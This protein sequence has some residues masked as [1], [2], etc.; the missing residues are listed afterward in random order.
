MTAKAAIKTALNTSTFVPIKMP[1]GEGKWS[2]TY[3]TSDLSAWLFA[4]DIAGLDEVP[5]LEE[6]VYEHTLRVRS[7]DILFFAKATVGTPNLI[8]FTAQ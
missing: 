7:D 4:T 5:M 8:F 1:N 6:A 3:Y 2:V